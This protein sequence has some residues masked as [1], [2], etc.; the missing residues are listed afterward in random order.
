MQNT[1]KKKNNSKS[2]IILNLVFIIM[3]AAI[4]FPFLLVLSVSFSDEKEIVESGY[5]L[6]PKVFSLEA[7]KYIFKKPESVFSAYKVTIMFSL[8]Y[9]VLSVFLMACLAYMLSKKDLKGRS[10]ISFYVYFTMLFSG[11]LV[12]TYILNTQ[13]LHLGDT[14][15]IYIL[16]TLISPWYTFMIRT[17]FSDIPAEISESAYV[18]GAS[19]FTILFKIILPLSK[20]VIAAVSLFM[21]L[22]KWNDWYT[23]MLY[24]NDTKLISLQYLLQKMM[25]NISLLNQEGM[26]SFMDVSNVP[27]ETVRMAM[28]VIVAGPA[29][30]VFPFFQKYFV[31]GLTVGS[32]KG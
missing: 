13:Y 32:V 22:A 21:L 4:I 27:A 15:W 1:L 19:D 30:I 24:I 5:S 26:S 8:I 14:I 2:Q 7:Y 17:F 12:P 3:A 11:G 29:L 25:D 20:P 23:A 18:D 16:P 6:I 31:K 10:A 28:A 9:M